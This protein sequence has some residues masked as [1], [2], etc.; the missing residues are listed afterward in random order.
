MI[1][2]YTWYFWILQIVFFSFCFSLL[3]AIVLI[4]SYWIVEMME[5]KKRKSL[6]KWSDEIDEN[7]EGQ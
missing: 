6:P 2:I 4:V 5:K 1:T 7:E 3:V